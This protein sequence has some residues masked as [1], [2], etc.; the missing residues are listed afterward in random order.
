M[1]AVKLSALL[2]SGFSIPFAASYWQLYVNSLVRL[3]T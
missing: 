1:F 2:L 3:L